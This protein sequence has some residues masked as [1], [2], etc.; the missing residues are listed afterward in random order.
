MGNFWFRL[1]FSVFP[2]GFVQPATVLIAMA[3]FVSIAS[4]MKRFFVYFP[5]IKRLYTFHTQIINV[6]L[7]CVLVIFAFYPLEYAYEIGELAP[8]NTQFADSNAR[9]NTSNGRFF[10]EVFF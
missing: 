6:V 10:G 7:L 1:K 4:K 2:F 9:T 5:L 3:Y 8:N